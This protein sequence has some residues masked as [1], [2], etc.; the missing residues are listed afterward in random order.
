MDIFVD[1]RPRLSEEA[2]IREVESG[3]MFGMVRCDVT[4]PHHL[5]EILEDMQPI[6]KHPMMGCDDGGPIMKRF[7]EE[8]G[9]LKK[10]TT[11]LLASYY[12]DDIIL[13]TLLLK[14]LSE[15]GIRVTKVHEVVQCKRVRCCQRFGEEVMAAR[16]A[17]D[18]KKSKKIIADSTKLIGKSLTLR[19]GY[20]LR[21]KESIRVRTQV[22][23]RSA[24]QW[25]IKNQRGSSLTAPRMTSSGRKP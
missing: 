5:R 13:A 25:L 15:R 23:R 16:R 14:W 8:H 2:I 1:R 11:V 21:D 6:I 24:R 9:L 17:G 18:A 10:P 12:A 20:P 4:T 19:S 7:A 3:E 22:A